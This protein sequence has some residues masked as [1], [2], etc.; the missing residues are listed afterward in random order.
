MYL[1]CCSVGLPETFGEEDR[2]EGK[3][4]ALET[5]TAVVNALRITLLFDK[6]EKKLPGAQLIFLAFEEDRLR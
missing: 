6:L 5:V 2:R 3:R 1:F 4:I